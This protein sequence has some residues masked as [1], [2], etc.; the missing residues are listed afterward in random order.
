MISADEGRMLASL[1]GGELDLV[2]SPKPRRY[3]EVGLVCKLLYQLAPLVYARRAHPL[4]KSKALMELQAASWAIVGASVSGRVDMLQEAFSVRDMRAPV[5]SA[6][7]PDYASLLHLMARSDLL[8]VL[9][10]PVLLECTAKGQIEPLR[11][12]ETLPLYEVHV[13]TPARSPRRFAPVIAALLEQVAA[14]A[15][16]SPNRA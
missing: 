2:I 7:C 11:L 14:S 9:P 15:L 3:R 12:R 10:H 8:G 6:S 13:F 5:V 16:N 1:Q 4:G